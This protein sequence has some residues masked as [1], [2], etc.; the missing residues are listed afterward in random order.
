MDLT[1]VGGI[2]GTGAAALVAWFR[3]QKA[4]R[5]R[6]IFENGEKAAV[7]EALRLI[8]ADNENNRDR[9]DAIERE[10]RLHRREHANL[11]DQTRELRIELNRLRDEQASP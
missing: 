2:I 9:I 5:G 1:Q 3:Y 10:L 7:R 11:L 6:P 4:V 8:G